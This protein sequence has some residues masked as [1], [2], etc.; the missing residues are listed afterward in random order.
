MTSCIQEQRFV[1]TALGSTVR[2]IGSAVV[3]LVK[4]PQKALVDFTA[5]RAKV[6][7]MLEEVAPLVSIPRDT[8]T[9]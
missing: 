7:K 3:R 9:R 1:R 2:A 5:D 6:A 8:A 4:S